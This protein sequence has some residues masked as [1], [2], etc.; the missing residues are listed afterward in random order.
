MLEHADNLIGNAIQANILAECILAGE[1]FFL[2]VGADHGH[3]RVRKVVGLAEEAAFRDIHLPHAA[4]R[5]IHA[6]H[7]IIRTPRA[8]SDHAI[9]ECLRRNALQ[10]WN[11]SANV[12]QIV[13]R[14][15][16]LGSGLGASRLQLGA[17]R[18]NENQ[19]G[20]ERPESGPQSTF[21]AGSVGEQKYDRGDS[22]SHAEHGQYTAAPVVAQSVVGLGCEIDDHEKQLLASS[23]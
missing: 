13:N 22:P 21:E 18:K 16:N 7:A 8:K 23:Y 3:P 17:A 12:V 6:A 19:V 4:V 14:Q 10:Q 5:G 15:A 2:R 20:A 1:Q 9:L 11:L